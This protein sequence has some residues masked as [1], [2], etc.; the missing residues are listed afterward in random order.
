MKI[1]FE[2]QVTSTSEVEIETPSYFKNY[3]NQYYYIHEE[4]MLK[5]SGDLICITKK[6]DMAKDYSFNDHLS[7]RYNPEKISESEFM[8][9]YQAF[10]ERCNSIVNAPVE[11]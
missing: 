4:G 2:K 1:K 7:G 11:I 5:I 10:I 3:L 8:E 9:A 6:D